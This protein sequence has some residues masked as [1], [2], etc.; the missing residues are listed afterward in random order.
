MSERQGPEAGSPDSAIG[1]EPI[2]ESDEPKDKFSVPP[3]I[4]EPQRIQ[5]SGRGSEYFG[6]WIVNVLLSIVT[7]GVWTAWAKVRR[8]RYFQGHTR[9]LGDPL[10]YHATGWMIFKGRFLAILV[11]VAFSISTNFLAF[12]HPAAPVIPGL[13]LLAI[14]PWAINMSLRF[15]A[16]MTSWRNVHFR[17]RGTYWGVFKVF[18]LWPLAG[19]LSLGTCYPLAARAIRHY[20][21]NNYQFGTMNFSA[22]SRVKPYYAAFGW[23]LL[24]LIA[25]SIT[26]AVV[27]GVAAG[28]MSAISPTGV[29]AGAS[30]A[31]VFLSSFVSVIM[32]LLSGLVFTILT[33]NIIINS[34][35][36]GACLSGYHPHPLYVVCTHFPEYSSVQVEAEISPAMPSRDSDGIVAAFRRHFSVV[37]ILIIE[38]DLAKRHVA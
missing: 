22:D 21:A 15:S 13:A 29:G 36:L 25:V 28:V 20:L 33:R 30:Q 26:A 27:V 37:E 12:V 23:S 24:F 8:V 32:F 34:L 35:R 9:I 6:I 14:Y 3:A 11:L 1:S 38:S 10:E 4:P 16:R 17:W 2:R 19:A 31:S 18:F 7:L 5:F